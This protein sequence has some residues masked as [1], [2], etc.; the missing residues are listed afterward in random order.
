VSL[1]K[2]QAQKVFTWESLLENNINYILE[3]H[4]I[5]CMYNNKGIWFTVWFFLGNILKNIFLFDKKILLTSTYYEKYKKLILNK[6][7]K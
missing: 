5:A 7:K 2:I 4:L 6:N 1:Y 3:P